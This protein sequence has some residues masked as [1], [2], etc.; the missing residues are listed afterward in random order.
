MWLDRTANVFQSGASQSISI[1]FVDN[2]VERCNLN[3]SQR[4][5]PESENI[6]QE[7]LSKHKVIIIGYDTEMAKWII[8]SHHI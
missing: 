8:G 7:L 1:N 4:T 2:S 5:P 6:P 3:R